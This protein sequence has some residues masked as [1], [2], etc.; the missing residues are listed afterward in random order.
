M[1]W[2]RNPLVVPVL[3]V[4]YSLLMPTPSRSQADA[5][6]AVVIGG[7]GFIG[8]H[9]V[10]AL[11]QQGCS[12][13]VV[14]NLDPLVH[15]T[16]RPPAYLNPGA[17][18]VQQ[19]TRDIDGLR[20]AYEGAELLYFLAGAVGVGDSMY[21]VRHYADVNLLGCANVLEILANSKHGVRK[22][23]L[24]SSVTVYGE[25]KY[26]CP[27]H[28]T[29]FPSLRSSEQVLHRQWEPT[30]PSAAPGT[31]CTEI[32]QPLPTDENKSA[33]PQSIYAITKRTQEEMALA[34]GRAHGIPVTVL[35]Y[36]NV[37]GP[38]QAVSNPY[39][40]VAKIFAVDIFSGKSPLIY[41]DGKQTRDFVHVSDIVQANVLAAESPKADGEIFNI[42]TGRPCSI[43]ELAGNLAERAGRPVPLSP[44]GQFRA[45]D[46]RHCFADI[47][48]AR[49]LLGYV[50]RTVF[51]QGLDNLLPSSLEGGAMSS[52]ADAEMRQRGLIR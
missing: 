46:V 1:D 42:G 41:E 45:G 4:A 39:T 13:R 47:S 31:A 18:F 44:T 11:L 22:L 26:S 16:G 10:D 12:V 29:V 36:F 9:L 30:C 15:P 33:S 6:R 38:R 27:K 17:E 14:D 32:L 23:I 7:A 40:G 50:P 52:V 34:V 43:L 19:D 35:R 49:N 5:C 20:R 2:R 51:P 37:F 25:G 21:R 28:G 8:S 24:A 3:A 48:K